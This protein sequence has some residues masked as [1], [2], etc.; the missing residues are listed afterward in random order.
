MRTA[1]E[2]EATALGARYVAELNALTVLQ[3]ESGAASA[4]VDALDS[5]LAQLR[6]TLADDTARGSSLRAD[7]ATEQARLAELLASDGHARSA[8]RQVQAEIAQRE[9]ERDGIAAKRGD[10]EVRL[11]SA[12]AHT[13]DARAQ[14]ALA[15]REL[16]SEGSV[17]RGMRGPATR[18]E[19]EWQIA[20]CARAVA[21]L[22]VC[23]IVLTIVTALSWSWEAR[24]LPVD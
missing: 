16:E 6:R 7:F 9:A 19:L 4:A 5:Q 22:G 23:V 10:V 13:A 20:L 17:Y 12:R 11:A 21:A 1:L 8:L 3:D 18:C 15:L 24:A 14:I 2:A